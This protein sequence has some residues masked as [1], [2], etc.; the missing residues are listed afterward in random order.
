[1]RSLIQANYR[2]EEDSQIGANQ[3]KQSQIYGN[4]SSASA[5][6]LPLKVIS[7]PQLSLESESQQ[8][9][10]VRRHSPSSELDS[11]D[12]LSNG[13]IT[14]SDT[15]PS[16]NQ[17]SQSTLCTRVIKKLKVKSNKGRPRKVATNQRN[18]F[19]IGIK[20]K[21]KRRKQGGA[22]TSQKTK[23]KLATN[24]CL[25]VIPTAVVGSTVKEALSILETAEN[26]GLHING[27]R[28]VVVKEVER[29]LFEG[30][31]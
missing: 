8:I 7:P 13:H 31:L 27:N 16:Q 9:Y 2:A 25:Q 24:N 26:M 22:N 1:M 30:E 5:K 12:T 10:K 17:S 23:R 19:D 28:E 14:N 15:I 3:E 18:P 6:A 20:F 29:R 11:T 4:T 21:F